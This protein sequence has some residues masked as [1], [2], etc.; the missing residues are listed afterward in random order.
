MR[1]YHEFDAFYKKDSK[2][3]ILGSIPSRKS[4]EDGFYYAHPQNRFWKVLAIVYDEDILQTTRD[5]KK[6]LEKHKIALWDVCESCLIHASSDSSIRDVKVNDLNRVLD[7]SQ[8]EVIFTTGKKAYELYNKYSRE[9]T[10]MDAIYLSSTSSANA[11][12][13]IEDLVHEYSKIKDITS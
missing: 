1:V 6:F 4:R 12:T 8:V 7:N 9:K 11:R 10:G 13:S 3:L 5:K 2:V